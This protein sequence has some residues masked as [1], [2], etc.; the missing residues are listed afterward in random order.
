M[1]FAVTSADGGEGG[2]AGPPSSLSGLSR[3]LVV[4]V[5]GEEGGVTC[6]QE[7]EDAGEEVLLPLL[8]LLAL[9]C[10]AG[11][12]G[13]FPA[14]F[15]CVPSSRWL[16]ERSGSAEMVAVASCFSAGL[17]ESLRPLA[18]G[19][20]VNLRGVVTTRLPLRKRRREGGV[21]AAVSLRRRAPASFSCRL[22]VCERCEDGDVVRSDCC[23]A[24][25]RTRLA[26]SFRRSS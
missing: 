13:C 21:V 12:S 2:Q 26:A 7:E 19:L 17:C 14:V 18:A 15:F 20:R 9:C 23:C 22:C 11:E 6:S 3:G 4:G 8:L 24:S 16:S 10:E 5:E 1:T 25:L